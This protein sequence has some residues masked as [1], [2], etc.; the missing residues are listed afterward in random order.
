[1]GKR[2]EKTVDLND[3][4]L[5]EIIPA[6]KSNTGFSPKSLRDR[7]AKIEEI[8]I[9]K[10]ELRSLREELQILKSE[11]TRLR[12]SATEQRISEIQGTSPELKI[13]YKE[14]TEK[15]LTADGQAGAA[16]RSEK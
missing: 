4:Q 3:G 14:F 9:T 2:V 10:N 11:N 16:Y 15:I 8:I 7:A 12:K 6:K 13:S 1:M 5:Y